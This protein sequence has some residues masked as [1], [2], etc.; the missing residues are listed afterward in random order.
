MNARL[1]PPFARFSLYFAALALLV[2]ALLGGCDLGD[3]PT[4][5][6]DS[7]FGGSDVADAGDTSPP[8]GD[9]NPGGDTDETPDTAPSDAGSDAGDA[10]ATDADTNSYAE[11]T[12]LGRALID[13]QEASEI[14]PRVRFENGVPRFVELRVKLPGDPTDDTVTRVLTFLEQHRDLFQ[15]DDVDRDLYLDRFRDV[16]APL[17]D[18]QDGL[19]AKQIVFS[20]RVDDLAVEYSR[21][22]L[23]V[24]D[25]YLVMAAG[26]YLPAVQSAFRDA[27]KS[28]P[29]LSQNEA[30]GRAVENSGLRS[31]KP[32]TVWSP[33]SGDL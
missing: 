20:Q 28:I 25:D 21:L 7:D 31:V 15:I 22:S 17:G 2:A 14:P 3:D 13:L 33:S 12:P 19:K 30:R 8:P 24:V 26:H 9:T 5:T 32:V 4:G 11:P 27:A 16:D 6:P 10:D 1:R 23:L 29:E 18:G